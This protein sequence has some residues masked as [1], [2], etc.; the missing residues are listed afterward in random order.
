MT[1]GLCHRAFITL[2]KAHLLSILA[3]IKNLIPTYKWLAS[4]LIAPMRPTKFGQSLNGASKEYNS[5]GSL[6]LPLLR[7]RLET[8]VRSQELGF[9]RDEQ[10]KNQELEL[11]QLFGKNQN[12]LDYQRYEDREREKE[13]LIPIFW[14]NQQ[15]LN[16]VDFSRWL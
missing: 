2:Q 15:L 6:D 1:K 14:G 12:Q 11:R 10:Q 4:R 3:Q 8:R 16:W 5:F 13:R 9:W 7:L